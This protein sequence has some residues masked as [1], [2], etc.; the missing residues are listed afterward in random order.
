MIQIAS[1]SLGT[2][3]CDQQGDFEE[4][5]CKTRAKIW[6]TLQVFSNS[7]SLSQLDDWQPRRNKACQMKTIP[8]WYN[9]LCSLKAMECRGSLWS[10][11]WV[12]IALGILVYCFHRCTVI[13][14]S[15]AKQTCDC[16]WAWSWQDLNTAL[17]LIWKICLRPIVVAKG[18]HSRKDDESYLH[19]SLKALP[20]Y[21]VRCNLSRE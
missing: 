8:L 19:S 9:N 21:V 10:V 16:F 17:Y 20:I 12:S 3:S 14:L 6:Q 15:R 13:G 1:F 4:L 5:Q 2:F 7:L 11:V 18:I